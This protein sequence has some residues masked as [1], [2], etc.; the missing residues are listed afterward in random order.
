MKRIYIPAILWCA[1]GLPTAHA[2]DTIHRYVDERGRSM[3][4]DRGPATVSDRRFRYVG[5]WSRKGWLQRRYNPSLRNRNRDRFEP[6]IEA[7]ARRA[8]L[9]V[10]LVHAV[11]D[12]E[13]SYDPDAVSRAG[14]VGLMQL[15]PETARRYGVRE[16]TDPA[17]NLDGGTRY[18][19]DLLQ[20]FGGDLRIS[21]AA[22]N[23]GENAVIRYNYDIPPYRET[24]AYVAKVLDY[25]DAY[26][27]RY[28][29]LQDG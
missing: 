28:A 26:K 7:A 20:R 19:S 11:V 27:K 4:T 2:G 17:Q 18:L 9:S 24:R 23:A 10:A 22:Y 13:S 6:A 12:A 21:L 8:S 3:F 25:F 29:R 5:S 1:G 16:R 14:A 15:M